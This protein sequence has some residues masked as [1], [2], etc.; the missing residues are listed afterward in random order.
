MRGANF[1][2]SALRL[3]Q[4]YSTASYQAHDLTG[5]SLVGINLAGVNLAGQNLTNASFYSRHADQCQPQPGQPHECDLLACATLTGANLPGPKCGG[6]RLD[7]SGHLPA[8]QLLLD[9]QLPG[10]RFDRNRPGT[11]NLAGVNLAGQNLTNAK[12]CGS[13][14]NANLSQ[15]NLTSA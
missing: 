3:A 9:G 15:A 5:I 11:V 1:G 8:A 13:L 4:L 6:R 7:Q 2:F 12:F 10:P 14:T